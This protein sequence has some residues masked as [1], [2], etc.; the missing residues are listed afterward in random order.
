MSQRE[1]TDTADPTSPAGADLAELKRAVVEFARHAS[2]E[3]STHD[4]KLLPEI[5]RI[6]PSGTVVYVAHT[7]KSDIEDVI[8]VAT[9]V[10]AL[11]FTAS[12]HIVARQIPNEQKLR[13]TLQRLRLQGV[14]R[15]LLV[16]G[17]LDRPVGPFTSTLEVIDSGALQEAGLER[18]GVAGHPEGNRSITPLSLNAALRHKQDFARASGIAVHIVTQFGFNPEAICLWDRHLDAEG[19][20]LPVHVG[21]AGPTPLSKLIKFALQCGVGHSMHSLVKDM[22]AMTNLA[23]RAKGPEEILLHV[24]LD[25]ASYAGSHLVQP[26]FYAFGG[27]LATA[28]WLRAVLHGAF[29]LEA[30]GTKFSINPK[31]LSS[32]I[33]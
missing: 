28:R 10:Q 6:L 11:G 31:M 13:S 15:A 1:A 14:R 7:P 12:P 8:R 4:E 30:D 33:L 29:D 5:A 3:I 32:V 22:G 23:R 2:T 16:A 21:I 18:I 9:K 19:I 24:A 20:S 17:D 27:V 26:H 25:R